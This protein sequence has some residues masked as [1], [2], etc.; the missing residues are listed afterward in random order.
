MGRPGRRYHLHSRGS[1][2][3]RAAK[4]AGGGSCPWRG[5]GCALA[6]PQG[7]L[8]NLRGRANALPSRRR[9]RPGIRE[10]HEGR[11][12]PAGRTGKAQSHPRKH[13]RC[14]LCR[15]FGIPIHIR[16]PE[17]GGG[18]GPP[19]QRTH[20]P[21]LLDRIPRRRGHR[22]IPD[23]PPLHDGAEA[24][25]LRGDIADYWPAS[26]GEHLPREAGRIVVLFPRH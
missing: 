24:G 21:A 5:G 26:R 10:D 12:R 23:A 13:Q 19:S 11:D 6:S 1:V 14:V 2:L 9:T 16:K 4:R 22:V 18:M 8:A 7:R 25:A 15:G 17:D 20:R 3:G